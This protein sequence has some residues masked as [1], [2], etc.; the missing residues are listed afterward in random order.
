[1]YQ[2]YVESNNTSLLEIFLTPLTI[3]ASAKSDE[4]TSVHYNCHSSGGGHYWD[5][6]GKVGTAW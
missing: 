6:L 4:D 5:Q 3:F 1:M 2:P